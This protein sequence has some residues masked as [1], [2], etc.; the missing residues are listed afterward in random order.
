MTNAPEIQKADLCDACVVKIEE[1][2]SR[3][4]DAMKEYGVQGKFVRQ[5][6]LTVVHQVVHGTLDRSFID[7]LKIIDDETK[8]SM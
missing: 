3:S 2:L 4:S 1:W 7:R 8:E 5:M 6:L